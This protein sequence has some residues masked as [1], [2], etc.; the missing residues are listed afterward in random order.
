MFFRFGRHRHLSQRVLNEYLDGLLLADARQRADRH[1]T[2]CDTC[3]RE[4]EGATAVVSLLRQL[5]Q[6]PVRRSFTLAAPPPAAVQ[7]SLLLRLPNW[8]Y[9]GAASLAGLVLAVLVSAD[10]VG[11]PGT[12]WRD[13]QSEPL[14]AAPAPLGMAAEG[15]PMAGGD[16][17]VA[18]KS[19]EPRGI[20]PEASQVTQPGSDAARP[21]T[22]TPK[23]GPAAAPAPPG[24]PPGPS[25][26]LGAPGPMPS[27]DPA[28]DGVAGVAEVTVASEVD[29][30]QPGPTPWF[31]RALEGLAAVAALMFLLGLRVKV[32]RARR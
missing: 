12:L 24:G 31:W 5:P 18:M 20:V 13:T 6:V 23:P 17:S 25:G 8:S 10:A 28:A 4:L 3:R 2:A 16:Q 26:P 27:A 1:L 7:A 32:R 22:L 21:P 19:A 11:L 15:T 14:I 30:R 29:A 9:A